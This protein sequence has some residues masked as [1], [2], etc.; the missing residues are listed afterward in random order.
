[1]QITTAQEVNFFGGSGD[2]DT[3]TVT[4]TGTGSVLSVTP[5]SLSTANVFLDGTP[6]IL[7]PT[8]SANNPGQNGGG[9]APDL[10][11]SGLGDSDN[12]GGLFV[13]GGGGTA[14]TS[15]R[16]RHYRRLRRSDQHLRLGRQRHDHRVDTQFGDV[17]SAV[18]DF[19]Y[20][21]PPAMLTTRSP[22][23]TRTSI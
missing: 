20:P 1:M 11:F 14:R 18:H 15:R 3:A 22:S 2:S 9:E 6:E 10:F 13:D 17:H 23:A 12:S 5:T 16:Q 19:D 21:A 8:S 4:G 7:T